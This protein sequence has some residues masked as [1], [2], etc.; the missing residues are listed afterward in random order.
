MSNEYLTTEEFLRF[1]RFH[2]E[3]QKKMAIE[4]ARIL[5]SLKEVGALKPLGEP[6]KEL[7][8]KQVERMSKRIKFLE[9]EVLR[10]SKQVKPKETNEQSSRREIPGKQPG[11]YHIQAGSK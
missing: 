7:L 9:T 5:K 11:V 10:L 6:V 4:V 1:K 2:Y 3:Q 8:T